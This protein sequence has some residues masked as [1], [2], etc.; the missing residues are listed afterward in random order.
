MNFDIKKIN[1]NKNFI[2]NALLILASVLLLTVTVYSSYNASNIYSTNSDAIVA[3]Y[4]F[5]HGFTLHQVTLP[6]EHSNILKIPL[7][8]IQGHLPYHFTSFMLVN[9][10][11]VLLTIGAWAFLL[12]RLFGRK[13]EIPILLLLTSL[14]FTSLS[15]N[16]NIVYTTVRNIEYPIA[17]WF[18]FIIDRLLK[19]LKNSRRQLVLAVIGSLL[20]GLVL[21]GDSLF[22]YAILLPILLVIIWYWIQSTRFTTGMVRAIG[23]VI[24]TVT[25]A[26]VT[27]LIA[28]SSGLIT[29]NST[30]WV[31]DPTGNLKIY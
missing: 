10:G 5:G 11:L 2:H 12:I 7:F 15:F 26:S 21:A 31:V 29:F 20:F 3:S 9:I 6:L 28:S 17:L 30:S 23:L 16:L 14:M 1:N 25:G 4:L 18:I 27:K 8:Y 19:E 24:A 22:Y 13:Y